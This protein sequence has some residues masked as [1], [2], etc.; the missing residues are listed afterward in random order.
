MTSTVELPSSYPNSTGA[1]KRRFARVLWGMLRRP[2]QTPPDGDWRVWYVRGG[3][4][5]GKTRTGSES[6]AAEIADSI[7][8]GDTDIQGD[9]AVIAPTFAD[10][11]DTCIEGSSG[12]RNALTGY[13]DKWNRSMGQM[14]LV[15]G[16]TVFCDGADDGALRIQGK[17]LRGAW[18]DEV[19]LWKQW[20]TAWD[21]SIAFAVRMGA[22]HVYAT[23]TPKA[24]HGLV[25]LLMRGTDDRPAEADHITHMRTVDNLANLS[26]TVV[27]K[28]TARYEGTRLGRQ[29]L[30]GELIDEV[31][32][33]LWHAELITR[34]K[35]KPELSRVVVGVDPPGGA[36]EAGIVAAGL[37]FN[38]P[39]GAAS[40]PH[41]IV[42]GDA[43]TEG[44]PDTWGRA[45][46]DLYE[47]E[48]ADRVVGETN[49]G[50]D[51]V[52]HVI[53]TVDRS[54]SYKTVR[55]T[56]G[57]VRRAEPIV[58][59]YEQGRVHHYGTFSDLETEMTTWTPEEPWSPNRM[60]ALVWALTELGLARTSEVK[61]SVRQVT[62]ARIR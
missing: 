46:A 1:A 13:V 53:R 12:L 26:P 30:E 29:E 4:G 62:Q 25:K 60:D 54:M 3:R 11:R 56:R 20:E 50:G 24:A 6:L 23:G 17:N 10:A 38:C 49:Y 40:Q 61:S 32:G 43:S 58:A 37:T 22:G 47:T 51:M 2:E 31:E 14:V 9:W 39:C 19:G 21:E 48:H 7:E 33:A 57:K 44:S 52:E 35:H 42:L 55:A 15:N 59:L 34:V 5:S 8:A 16:A 36:T 41:G 27:A 28:L 45:V 18:C